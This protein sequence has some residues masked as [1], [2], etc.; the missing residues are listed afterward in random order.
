MKEDLA[1]STHWNQGFLEEA[2]LQ[3]GSEGGVG[4]IRQMQKGRAF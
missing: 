2:M 3:L 1:R 4:V